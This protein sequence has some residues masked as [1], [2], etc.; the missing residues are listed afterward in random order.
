MVRARVVCQMWHHVSRLGVGSRQGLVGT[1]V[2]KNFWA[3]YSPVKDVTCWAPKRDSFTSP[4]IFHSC[5]GTSLRLPRVSEMGV[6]VKEYILGYRWENQLILILWFLNGGFPIAGVWFTVVHGEH[7]KP[8]SNKPVYWMWRAVKRP[9][10]SAWSMD[11]KSHGH[12]AKIS[13][14]RVFWAITA[15]SRPRHR[16]KILQPLR[17]LVATIF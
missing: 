2:R 9:Q 15:R 5:E 8:N 1:Y 11:L 10:G 3:L 14:C 17:H 13:Q 6:E 12:Q 16:S 7:S 4:G